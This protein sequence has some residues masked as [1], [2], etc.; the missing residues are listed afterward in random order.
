MEDCLEE[1][2]HLWK[3]AQRAWTTFHTETDI[4][5]KAKKC[6]TTEGFEDL[7]VQQYRA[8]VSISKVGTASM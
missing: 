8:T 4:S 3:K 7:S 2:E 1:A 5:E 6:I